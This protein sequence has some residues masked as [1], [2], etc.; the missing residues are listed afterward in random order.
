MKALITPWLTQHRSVTQSECTEMRSRGSENVSFQVRAQEYSAF[1]LV[2]VTPLRGG[3]CN[4]GVR[5]GHDTR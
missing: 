2:V 1:K 5:V 3:V 4:V